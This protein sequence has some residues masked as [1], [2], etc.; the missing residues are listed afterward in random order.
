MRGYLDERQR[1]NLLRNYYEGAGH[2]EKE[3]QQFYQYVVL[4]ELY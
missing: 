1:F 4:M 2:N 3:V